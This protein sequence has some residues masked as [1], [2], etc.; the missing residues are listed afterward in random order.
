[1]KAPDPPVAFGLLGPLLVT[2][3]H[4]TDIHIPQAKQ[5]VI[6]AALLLR[7]NA[8]VSGDRLA[9][10]LWQDEPPPNALAV[11]RTYVARLRRTLGQ[12]GTRLVSRPSGYAIEVR[13]IG[14]FDLEELERFRAESREA[15][16]AGQWERVAS[17]SAQALSLWRG[18]PLEDIPSAALH[19]SAAERLDELRVQLA[20]TRLDAELRLGR[21]QYVL[22]ELRQFAAEHP[23]R[24]HIQAQLML[25]YYRCG[26]QAEAL[27]VYRKVRVCL[28]GEL[29]VEPGSELRQLHQSI[30]AADPMLDSPLWVTEGLA[31]PRRR[32]MRS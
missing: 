22:A 16:E 31:D 14:E 7:A 4:G 32:V 25:A 29:G 20:T 11:I 2:D 5:R 18:T 9:D 28:V 27:T 10:A 30:L 3:A 1:M 17:L 12:V 19:R 6:M 13:E 24:E 15:A 21:E 23:L 8:A 26:R